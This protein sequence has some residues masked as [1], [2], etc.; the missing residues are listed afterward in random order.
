MVLL[1]CCR[2]PHPA[3]SKQPLTAG[4]SP[5]FM[6]LPTLPSSL[7]AHLIGS[8]S[9]HRCSSSAGLDGT[10]IHPHMSVKQEALTSFRTV[11]SERCDK[12][13]VCVGFLVVTGTLL[14]HPNLTSNTLE[15]Y[16]ANAFILMSAKCF[17]PHILSQNPTPCYLQDSPF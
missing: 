17:L 9:S 4:P 12:D 14:S 2:C 7:A 10:H 6:S 16:S 13:I 5:G 11:S 1:P 8:L 15:A 3:H